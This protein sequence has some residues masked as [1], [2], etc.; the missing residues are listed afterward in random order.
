M[1]TLFY[2]VKNLEDFT[3]MDEESVGYKTYVIITEMDLLHFIQFQQW[4]RPT[5][6]EVCIKYFFPYYNKLNN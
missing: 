3:V 2:M 6:T 5:V 4:I 1:N